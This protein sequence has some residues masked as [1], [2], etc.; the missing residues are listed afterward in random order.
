MATTAR[1][2]ALTS[3]HPCI[4][5]SETVQSR[6][7]TK[8]RRVRSR[9]F[10]SGSHAPCPVALLVLS[11][12]P[13]SGS[14]FGPDSDDEGAGQAPSDE[15]I[16]GVET[17]AFPDGK[18]LRIRQF[19]DH[20]TNGEGATKSASQIDHALLFLL[21]APSTRLYSA[22]TA[23]VLDFFLF[24]SVPAQPMPCGPRLASLPAGC[25]ASAKTDPSTD[26]VCTACSST[27]PTPIPHMLP[28]QPLP[29]RPQLPRMPLLQQ[30]HPSAPPL[31]LRLPP[32]P[33]FVA[34]ACLS[35]ALRAV[36]S[37]YFSPWRA[38]T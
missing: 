32:L 3:M 10:A 37:L 1:R 17:H 26:S 2:A 16:Y 9:C 13:S 36:L 7:T 18:T 19:D 28:P 23:P 31:L 27:Q 5:V 24:S 29:P 8:G 30:P 12:T 38:L 11:P 22:H 21:Y 6:P 4:S 15:P 20:I 14:M 34:S 35:S 25:A 33:L